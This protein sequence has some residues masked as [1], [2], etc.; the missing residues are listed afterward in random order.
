MIG[1]FSA[2]TTRLSIVYNGLTLNNAADPTDDTY[3]VNSVAVIPQLDTIED[4]NMDDDGLEA[5]KVR[6]VRLIVTI[7]GTIRAPTIARLF[8]KM[9]AFNAAF[10]PGRLTHDNPATA[11]FLPMTFSTPTLDTANYATGLVPSRYF[12]RPRKMLVPVV[13]EYTGLAAF[14]RLELE[15]ADPRRYLQTISTLNGAG[16]ADNTLADYRSFPVITITAAGAGSATYTISR[17]AAG[18]TTKQ[19][20]LNLSGLV[21]TDVVIVDMA[22]HTITKNGTATPSLYVSGSWWE[23]EPLSNTITI[24]NGT[25]MTT[26]TAWN[27]A[28]CA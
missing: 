16:A 4:P 18:Y 2:D 12:V 26:S 10:D 1:L 21:N 14:F 11:G 7:D 20:V 25:N 15:A 17:A 22:A 24:T 27:R 9:K 19:L 23:I 8:D 6:K 28:F 3:E 13:S 5:Y